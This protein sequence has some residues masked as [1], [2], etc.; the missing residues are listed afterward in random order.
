MVP[1]L[2]M[3]ATEAASLR[4]EVKW[5]KTMSRLWAATRPNTFLLYNNGQVV[6]L[7]N[8]QS[9]VMSNSMQTVSK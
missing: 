5:Q 3:K 9:S 6:N 4:L 8:Q 2:E 1:V 7:E